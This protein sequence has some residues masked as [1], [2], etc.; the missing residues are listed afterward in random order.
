MTN[1]DIVQYTLE[2]LKKAGADKAACSVSRGRKDE[3]NVE[4][5]KFSLLRTLFNDSLSMKVIKDGKKGVM[6]INKLDTDSI[7]EAVASCIALTSSAEADEAEDISEKIENKS[8]DQN[9]GGR[10]MDSLFMRTKE[11]LEQTK[12]QFPKITLESV[13]SDFNSAKTIFMNTNG[14]EFIRE[15]EFYEMGTSFAAKDGEKSSS[16]NYTGARLASLDKAFMDLG[17][18]RTLL[19]ESVKSLDTRG[20]DGKFVGK[21]IVSPSCADMI[22]GTIIDIFLSNGCLI[23]GTSRWKDALNTKVADSKLTMRFSPLNPDIIAGERFTADGYE[24]RD[25]DVIR[26]GVL[27]SFAL[28][29]YGSKKT[30]KPMAANTAFINVEVMSGDKPLSEMI[31]GI[32]KGIFLNRFSGASPVASGDISG[33]AK[34][35]FMIE[36]GEVTD[37]L[38]ETMVSFNI[39]DVL[40]NIVAISSERCLDGYSILPWT[41][42]DGITIS[43]A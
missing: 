22:W 9:I 42:F 27:K 31:K 5:D 25:T 40:Q 21:V 10:D 15:Y 39:I 19:E 20:I 38:K 18:Q 32:D 3:L 14:V 30:G 36:N 43:G 24:S 13:T 33:V 8:F 29:Q 17:L 7:N 12:D 1:N 35:S 23:D 28:T 11:F 4:A 16:F 41:C 26:D 6:S 2:E 34:N 37:A